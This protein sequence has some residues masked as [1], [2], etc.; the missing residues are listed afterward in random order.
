MQWLYEHTA[1][2]SARFVLGTVGENPLV[3]F[4]INPSTAEP[5]H[6]DRTVGLVRRL[7]TS[8]GFDSFVMLNVYA[9]RATDPKDL[10]LHFRP[11]LKNENE[12]QIA[13]VAGGRSLTLW[14]AWGHLVEERTYLRSLLRDI[15]A[16]PELANG[17]WVSRGRV[18]KGGHPHH[19]LYVK[20]DAPLEPFTVDHY[21]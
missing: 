8:N 17:C 19:P 1:D 3:C 7:A 14:A 21:R 4:G 5:N 2:N 16:L 13:A 15:V 20:K 11:E 12:R 10:H 18:T 6:L 9:Q